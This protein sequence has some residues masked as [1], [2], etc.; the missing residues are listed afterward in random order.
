MR[1]GLAIMLI[2]AGIAATAAGEEIRLRYSSGE[3][4][5]TYMWIQYAHPATLFTPSAE[6]YPLFLKSAHFG[7]NAE[8][9]NVRVKVWE[10][11]GATIGSMIGSFWVT[12]KKWPEWT[13]ADLS[14]AGIIIEQQDFLISTDDPYREFFVSFK[15]AAPALYPG[16]HFTSQDDITW[17]SASTD[18]AIECTVDTGYGIG[19]APTSFGRVKALYR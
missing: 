14:G 18:W 11:D 4:N 13:D 7:F 17:H 16:H 19:V 15:G 6:Q 1:Y 8:Y 9:Y 10:A 3:Y 5:R 12:T 2:A